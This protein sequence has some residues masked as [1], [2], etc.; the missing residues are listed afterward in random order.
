MREVSAAL[1]TSAKPAI[2]YGPYQRRADE[3]GLEHVPPP[4]SFLVV[5]VAVHLLG[6][7]SVAIASLNLG[8]RRLSPE[9][10]VP[11][12]YAPLPEQ[13]AQVFLAYFLNYWL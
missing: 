12:Q 2:V 8:R 4:R 10:F 1:Y 13:E 3:L 6:V 7:A 11:A 9:A 5:I